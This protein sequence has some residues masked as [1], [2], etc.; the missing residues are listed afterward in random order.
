M[1]SYYNLLEFIARTPD[2]TGQAIGWRRLED[3]FAN[4]AQGMS[5]I[6][7]EQ[8]LHSLCAFTS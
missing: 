8:A 7:A 6:E 2:A 5:L 4:L 3:F 1:V